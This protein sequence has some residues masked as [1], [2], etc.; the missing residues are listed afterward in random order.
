MKK[1]ILNTILFSFLAFFFIEIFSLGLIYTNI[2]TYYL[3]GKEIYQSISKS[4]QKKNTK[5]LLLGDSVGRQLFPNSSNNNSI[6]SLACNQAIGMV[7]HFILLN[8]YINSG[9]EIET[10]FLV[11]TPFSFRNNLDQKY[12]FHYFLKPFY[13][14]EFSNLF[15]E[16]VNHQIDKIPFKDFCR[17]P[18][19]LAT[20]WAPH[21]ESMDKINYTFLSPISVEYLN[22]IKQLSVKYKFN[23]IILPTPTNINKKHLID[24]LDRKEIV[25]NNLTD[26]FKNYFENIIYLDSTYFSDGTHLINPKEFTEY[27]KLNLLNTSRIH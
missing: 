6:N 1:F 16:N 19:I 4:K 10:V 13:K 25:N 20:S 2:Y 18:H 22:K 15:T 5:K 7:G 11:F 26:E 21:F 27:Y 17:V 12:T 3:P 23:L 9:N 24:K 14:N 8:N